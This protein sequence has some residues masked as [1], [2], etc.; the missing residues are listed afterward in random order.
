[1]STED[2]EINKQDVA[3]GGRPEDRDHAS[4][5]P[6]KAEL[7][8][9]VPESVFLHDPDGVIVYVNEAAWSTRGYARD[10]MLGLNIRDLSMPEFS[11]LFES[12][13]EEILDKGEARFD[14]VNVTKA[15]NEFPVSVAARMIESSDRKLILAVVRDITSPRETL[16]ALSDSL[17][18]LE[19]VAHGIKEGILLVTRDFR[20]RWANSAAVAQS[21]Y[22]MEEVIGN[23]CYKVSH[24]IDQPCAPPSDPCPIAELEKSGHPTQVVHEHVDKEGNISWV[25]VSAYPTRFEDGS[26][27]EFAHVSR[28]ITERI[29]AEEELERLNKELEAF[30]Y[31][32]SHDLRAPLRAIEQFA[33]IILEDHSGS[34][35]EE[36]ARLLHI[37]IQNAEH[38]RDLIE[39]LLS[40]SRLGR[41]EL[42][43]AE[44]DMTRLAEE[45]FA[46]ALA[47]NPD[48][49]V[50]FKCERLPVAVG[51]RLL[52]HQVLA[53]LLSNAVKFSAGTGSPVITVTGSFSGKENVYEVRDNGAGFDMKYADKLFKVFQRLHGEEY[54]GTGI[55]LANVQ[56]I[57]SRHGGRVW[58]EGKPGQGATF[59]FTL[60]RAAAKPLP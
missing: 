56:R 20:I 16:M 5:E 46:E 41:E 18:L 55:G 24:G 43:V 30:N 23:Y 22:S 8:D 33:L 54:E 50:R 9:S 2:L 26:P 17:Q 4:G 3:S 40:F 32:V 21:G 37:V 60:P 44:V 59:F 42:R 57:V 6:L 19:D 45:A 47:A 31:T 11:R 35:D 10:E 34:F 58:A 25:E 28:D 14:T 12:H 48:A 1:M 49:A 53:N 52:L 38:M 51:D 7:L 15:G 29:K 13:I 36:T 39:G 27:V